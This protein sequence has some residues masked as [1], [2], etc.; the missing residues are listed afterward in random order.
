[1]PKY[2][3]AF[4]TFAGIQIYQK[5]HPSKSFLHELLY[6]ST[7]HD[8][9]LTD[10]PNTCGKPNLDGFIEHRH[11]Q[12]I[13]TLLKEKHG[14]EGFRSPTQFGNHLKMKEFRVDGEWLQTEYLDC[15]FINSP[16]GTLL[17]TGPPQG[18]VK[19]LEFFL[20]YR[21]PSILRVIFSKHFFKL[22]PS[23]YRKFKNKVISLLKWGFRAEYF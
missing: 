22:V 6:Y 16:Y 7:I 2:H 18:R 21:I 14:I 4:I 5:N 23:Q 9:I 13:L 11:D 20:R 3:E 17:Y 15:P 8:E 1:M 12:S 19:S 10:A